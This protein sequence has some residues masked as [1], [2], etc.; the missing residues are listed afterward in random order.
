MYYNDNFFALAS[1][2][3]GGGKPLSCIPSE[4]TTANRGCRIMPT[5]RT[6]AD[7]LSFASDRLQQRNMG[8]CGG[9]K[10]S[11]NKGCV[12]MKRSVD[13][14]AGASAAGQLSSPRIGNTVATCS[15]TKTSPPRS[16]TSHGV[17]ERKKASLGSRGEKLE[18]RIR[19]TGTTFIVAGS[20]VVKGSCCTRG[21]GSG[22][23]KRRA[24]GA[25]PGARAT[26]VR[27]TPAQIKEVKA[28][29]ILLEKSC[30]TRGRQTT[31]L[32]AGMVSSE[33]L[34]LSPPGRNA[35]SSA[36]KIQLFLPTWSALV[37]E[38]ARLRDG[39]DGGDDA[40]APRS[41]NGKKNDGLGGERRR[42]KDGVT[43]SD[44][45]TRHL[46]CALEDENIS[47]GETGCY[48]DSEKAQRHVGAATGVYV[49]NRQAKARKGEEGVPATERSISPSRPVPPSLDPEVE[50]LLMSW[51][52][53]RIDRLEN[54]F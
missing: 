6:S 2:G 47:S 54:D 53:S 24:W 23:R 10:R 19:S 22:Q 7:R 52:K 26:S 13:K 32:V 1:P 3:E 36:A 34:P 42:E 14:A 43:G 29:E 9:N 50:R 11:A 4:Q 15:T 39:S 40:C 27:T 8:A 48:M 49:K 28:S 46:F 44:V 30:T 20:R 35:E 41:R 12:K 45:P 51:I 33:G 25:G 38:A 18:S 5:T 31:Q 16:H 37:S 21:V 17:R